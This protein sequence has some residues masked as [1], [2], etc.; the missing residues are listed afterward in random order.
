MKPGAFIAVQNTVRL[1]F[2]AQHRVGVGVGP[3]CRFTF[4]TT[5]ERDKVIEVGVLKH[6]VKMVFGPA[7]GA[8]TNRI[9]GRT[10]LGVV[11][12][13]AERPAPWSSFVSAAL[14]VVLQLTC[15]LEQNV[16]RFGLSDLGHVVAHLGGE[17]VGVAERA[18]DKGYEISRD[19][20]GAMVFGLRMSSRTVSRTNSA[21]V[22]PRDY[23]ADLTSF[24]SESEK[25]ASRFLRA[26]A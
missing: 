20:G 1:G 19:R 13:F 9:G 7:E 8:S 12:R 3:S 11:L 25:W 24:H 22:M 18:L 15:F 16:E 26:T 17:H 5:N 21:G 2:G 23:A 10:V 4:D 6:A 14:K